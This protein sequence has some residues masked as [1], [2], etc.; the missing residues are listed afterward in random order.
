[1]GVVY[2]SNDVNC[3]CN[4]KKCASETIES[5]C[6]CPEWF[7]WKYDIDQSDKRNPKQTYVGK[8]LKTKEKE[9]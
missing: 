2:I 8:H 7:K 6:G 1:M 3:P 5:C 9:I 4:I